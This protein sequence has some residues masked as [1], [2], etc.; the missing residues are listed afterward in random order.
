[1]NV[2]KVGVFLIAGIFLLSLAAPAGAVQFRLTP[3]GNLGGVGNLWGQVQS[4][5]YD[6]SPSGTYIVG[7]SYSN[8]TSPNPMAAFLWDSTMR[9]LDPDTTIPRTAWG[10][11]DA[12]YVVGECSGAPC[13]NGW[14]YDPVSSQIVDLGN[15]GTG[16]STRSWASGISEDGTV[17][18]ATSYLNWP[19]LTPFIARKGTN[20]WA[21][22][23]LGLNNVGGANKVKGAVSGHYFVAGFDGPDYMGKAILVDRNYNVSPATTSITFLGSTPGQSTSVALDLSHDSVNNAFTVVGYSGYPIKQA[24]QWNVTGSGIT[25]QALAS[26]AGPIESV[27]YGVDSF[28]QVVGT[29]GGQAVVWSRGNMENL[30]SLMDTTGAGWTLKEARSISDANHKIAGFGTNPQ[31]ETEAYVLEPVAGT[32]DQDNDG[33]TFYQECADRDAS[34]NPD[35]TEVCDESGIDEDCDGLIDEGFPDADRDGFAACRDCNDNCPSC[36]TGGVEV[37]RDGL[38]QDCNG[39]DLTIVVSVATWS[40]AKKTLTVTASSLYE[41]SANLTVANFGPL[42]YNARKKTWSAVFTGVASNP[43]SGQVQV[44]GPEGSVWASVT[45]K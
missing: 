25:V 4:I 37:V 41:A 20:G 9:D 26:M 30:N 6:I 23:W 40:K 2:K 38:D 43:G 1:M 34:R 7:G 44:S 21:M 10:V 42:V 36:H 17:V 19:G 5:A 16:I 39:Y 13:T 24:T 45:A 33:Y 31:G 18:G 14:V 11:N 15:L 35:A 8:K 28:G 12:G 22:E 29:F 27:A 32:E 3:L